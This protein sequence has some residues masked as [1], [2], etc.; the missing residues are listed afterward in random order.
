[1][2]IVRR[3]VRKIACAALILAAYLSGYFVCSKYSIIESP[4]RLHYREFPNKEFRAAYW[5]MGWLECRIRQQE[6]C[7]TTPALEYVD[8]V[9]GELW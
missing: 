6:V 1:M 9:P 8:F 7:L 5:P 3:H 4:F 2:R